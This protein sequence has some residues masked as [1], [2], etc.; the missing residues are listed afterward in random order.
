MVVGSNGMIAWG[1][2]NSAGDWSDLIELDVDP[3]DPDAYLTPEG[4]RSFEHHR[5]IIKIKGRADEV[6]DIRST[7][8]GP[9]IGV[10]HKNRPRTCAGWRLI[11]RART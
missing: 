2:T 7:I 10:D 8:W 5:E 1:L 3:A 11:P 4:K 6:L 9:V